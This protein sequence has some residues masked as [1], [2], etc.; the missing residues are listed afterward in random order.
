M[1]KFCRG[2][3]TEFKPKYK[4]NCINCK[5]FNIKKALEMHKNKN[6]L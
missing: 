4:N 3:H 6:N 5:A 2:A 1:K